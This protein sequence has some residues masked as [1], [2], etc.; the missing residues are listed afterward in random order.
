MLSFFC[1]LALP[2]Q[3]RPLLHAPAFAGACPR[4]SSFVGDWCKQEPRNCLQSSNRCARRAFKNSLRI[5]ASDTRAK[6]VLVSG[7]SGFVGRALVRKLLGSGKA[8]TLLARDTEKAR[9]TFNYKVE[10]IYFEATAADAPAK[11]VV[12]AVA[13]SDAIIN[14]AG[15]PIS[16]GR[17]TA[18]RKRRILESRVN[19]TLQLV[20]AVHHADRKPKVLISTSAVGYYGISEVETFDEDSPSIGTDFLASVAKKWEAA[21]QD[22]GIRTVINRFGIVLGPDGGALSRMLPLFN[23]FMGGTIGSGRQWISWIHIQ[24]LVNIIMHELESPDFQGVYNATA[25][26]PVQFQKFCD[27]LARALKR[28]NWLP[29][30]SFTLQL[31]LGEAAELVLQGQRVLPKRLLQSGLKFQ[32]QEIQPALDEI[33]ASWKLPVRSA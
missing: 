13:G 25:P 19:G 14:L 12:E 33:A 10:A 32:Y 26:T 21:A 23:L 5:E 9:K 28:P 15:E 8:V 4:V 20:R 24:D 7:G 6:T 16:E 1:L 2:N 29:V 18:E 31:I 11:E 22:A 27:S 17:W 3:Q 30:P